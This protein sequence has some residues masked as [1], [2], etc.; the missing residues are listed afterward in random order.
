MFENMTVQQYKQEDGTIVLSVGGCSYNAHQAGRRNYTLRNLWYFDN[1]CYTCYELAGKCVSSVQRSFD[2][3]VDDV[4]AILVDVESGIV[5][6]LADIIMQY[7]NQ[8]LSS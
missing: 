3:T 2:V 1:V 7:A 6:A 8:N 5:R 4:V